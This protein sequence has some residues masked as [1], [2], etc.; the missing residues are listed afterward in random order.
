MVD[1]SVSAVDWGRDLEP[2][3]DSFRFDWAALGWIMD[4]TRSGFGSVG[5]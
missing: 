1:F 5:R 2:S 4:L 3:Q